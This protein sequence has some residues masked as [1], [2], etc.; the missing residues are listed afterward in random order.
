M[1][2][3]R[4]EQPTWVTVNLTTRSLPIYRIV[5][6]NP[7][8]GKPSLCVPSLG[9]DKHPLK[10]IK[11]T[12]HVLHPFSTNDMVVNGVS[13]VCGYFDPLGHSKATIITIFSRRPFPP[14]NL[15]SQQLLY[16]LSFFCMFLTL[17]AQ[18]TRF[19]LKSAITI[20]H[21]GCWQELRR[22]CRPFVGVF[23]RN[24]SSEDST[25]TPIFHY[26]SNK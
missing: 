22:P 8:G 19:L 16:F 13:S 1:N 9:D 7:S 3:P 18:Q 5:L 26:D 14:Q 17:F 2:S 12:V 25:S 23:F 11:R 10:W 15:S 24:H 21:Q 6:D 4:V 20:R